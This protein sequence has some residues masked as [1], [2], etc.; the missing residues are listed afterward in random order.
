[1]LR[2]NSVCGKLITTLTHYGKGF[3]MS[4]T[5]KLVGDA[6]WNACT[7]VADS[8][9]GAWHGYVTVGQVAEC[10]EFT[11]QTTRKYMNILVEMGK[12]ELAPLDPRYMSANT[13]RVY[14]VTGE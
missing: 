3:T 6:V 2:G 9:R 1:M 4:R 14:K 5:S 7:L 8:N 13:T 11:K 12:L 10:G